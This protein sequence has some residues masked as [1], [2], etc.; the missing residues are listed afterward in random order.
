MFLFV[1]AAQDILAGKEQLE[2]ADIKGKVNYSKES[3]RKDY[4]KRMFRALAGGPDATGRRAR[5]I[6]NSLH[7]ISSNPDA[8]KT[9]ETLASLMRATKQKTI[10]DLENYLNQVYKKNHP[11][12]D[13]TGYR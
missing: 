6:D 5:D 7:N 1:Q 3:D 9:L 12:G 13:P 4:A 2:G 11:D 10:K 8:R